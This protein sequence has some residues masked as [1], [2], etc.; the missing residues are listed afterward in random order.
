[1]KFDT[2]A[3]HPA[4]EAAKQHETKMEF[5]RKLA[6]KVA[7]IQG[8]PSESRSVAEIKTQAEQ[9]LG[10]GL[11]ANSSGVEQED[12]VLEKV[13]GVLTEKDYKKF[14]EIVGNEQGDLSEVF[15]PKDTLMHTT[16]NQVFEKLLQ[17]GVIQT[18]GEFQKTPGASFTDGNF[19]EAV[20]F[21]LI[22][23]NMSGGGKEKRLQSEQYAEQLGGSLPETFVAYFWKNHVDIAKPYFKKLVAKIPVQDLKNLGINPEAE[24][25]TMEQAIK[26][27]TYFQPPERD[28]FGVTFV[29]DQNKSE[30]LDVSDSTTEGLQS[31]FEKRSF[32]KGGVPLSEA[33]AVLVPQSR[34]EEIKSKLAERDLGHIDVRASE[35]ME[36]RRILDHIE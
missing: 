14:I 12:S 26:I 7:G 27:G 8:N 29:Y 24:V 2:M 15:D 22:Y 18:D 23:D 34:I 25:A 33:S 10:Q 30:E 36:V 1:M 6:K 16:N 3:G 21:Q 32:H 31:I 9:E 4:E 28:G 13:K 35:E 20:S 17:S 5:E 11:E 19:P